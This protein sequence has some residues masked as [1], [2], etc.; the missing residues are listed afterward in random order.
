MEIKLSDIYRATLPSRSGNEGWIGLEPSGKKYHVIVP[1]DPQIA[2]GVMAC[3]TPT[4]GT[5]FGGYTGWLYFRCEPFSASDEEFDEELRR[6]TA[7][8]N[9][10]NL[11]RFASGFGIAVTITEDVAQGAVSEQPRHT[12][13]QQR[14]KGR[15]RV[16]E[17]ESKRPDQGAALK[18]TGC[19][20]TWDNITRLLADPSIT[21]SKYKANTADFRKGHF[22]FRH[23]CGGMVEVVATKLGRSRYAGKSLAGSHACPGFCYY[24]ASLSECAAVCEGS[25]FR[26][27]AG[28]LK[29]RRAKTG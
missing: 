28:K 15:F 25:V 5:P 24:E 16:A 17:L 29:T 19:S 14:K 22:V 23:S 26:R 8:Q 10:A 21:F 11:V 18:C 4:D 27:I 12:T 7:R 9:A 3:N 1:V 20:A 2:R 13:L 6:T